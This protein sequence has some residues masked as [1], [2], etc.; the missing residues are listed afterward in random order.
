MCE[1]KKVDMIYTEN[2]IMIVFHTVNKLTF[3][4]SMGKYISSYGNYNK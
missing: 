3:G 1:Y 2:S 4:L